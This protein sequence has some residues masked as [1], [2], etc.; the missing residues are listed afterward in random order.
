M[1]LV[2]TSR[3]YLLRLGVT[4]AI[5]RQ[6]TPAIQNPSLSSF[7]ILDGSRSQSWSLSLSIPSKCKV[8]QPKMCCQL[9]YV[10]WCLQIPGITNCC[11][12]HD[13][14]PWDWKGPAFYSVRLVASF[15]IPLPMQLLLLLLLRQHHNWHCRAFFA[16]VVVQLCSRATILRIP[17]MVFQIASLHQLCKRALVAS[18]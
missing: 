14:F 15:S 2:P 3:E 13:P 1:F 12:L 7:R 8:Q 5:T 18:S 9:I 16:R 6:S 10:V 17:H 11:I 4:F